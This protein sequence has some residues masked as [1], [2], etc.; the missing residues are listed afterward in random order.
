MNSFQNRRS[1]DSNYTR[2][3]GN[4]FGGGGRDGGNR[5]RSR[6]RSPRRGPGGGGRP[7]GGY[8]GG[9]GR[10]NFGSGGTGG[11]VDFRG[12]PDR[13][14]DYNRGGGSY[15]NNERDYGG[16]DRMSNLGADLQAVDYSRETV[17]VAKFNFYQEHADVQRLTAEEVG[18]V[19][20]SR[21]LCVK[22]GTNVPKPIPKF[23]HANFPVWMMDVIQRSGF[24]RP[25]P[26][27][28][29][30]WPIALSGRNMIGIAQTG[31]GKTLAFILPVLI[32]I[33]AQPKLQYGDGPIALI[34]APTRELAEQIKQETDKFSATSGVKNSVAY[35]GVPKR[36]QIYSLR[37][38]VEILIATPG[39]LIDFL[40]SNVTN[41]RR[42]TFLVLDEADRMLDMGFEP[43]IRKVVSQV[44]P[45]RQVLMLS[46]TWP[47]AVERLAMSL[48]G[49]DVIH[50][51]VGREDLTAN[52]DITQHVMLVN[53]GS[54]IMILSCCC[55][56]ILN[57]ADDLFKT[58]VM[59]TNWERTQRLYSDGSI[60]YR[61]LYPQ[62]SWVS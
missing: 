37:N 58:C 46:A 11:G 1:P 54:S 30:A 43:Q 45:T 62:G 35:G 34:M 40:S 48:M 26:I 14:N 51:L 25:S 44:R 21:D 56:N 16:N 15:Y 18:G 27:Q 53:V 17:S 32:H 33:Q 39:R 7:G 6:S 23:E 12:G 47:K 38:G 24:S 28:T 49:T 2:E 20:R 9:R 61:W 59:E 41:L 57:I 13:Y 50:I 60:D 4:D 29:M 5:A 8:E 22:S 19:L 55:G 10:S 31:S 36:Q 52:E 3:R 42:V